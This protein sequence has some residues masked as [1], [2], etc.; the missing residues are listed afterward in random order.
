MNKGDLVSY[1]EP[2]SKAMNGTHRN[3][4]EWA[5]RDTVLNGTYPALWHG[6]VLGLGGRRSWSPEPNLVCN[7]PEVIHAPEAR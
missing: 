2:P 5:Q 7:G 6:G 4:S 3:S 1:H